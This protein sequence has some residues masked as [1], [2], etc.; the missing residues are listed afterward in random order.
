MTRQTVGKEWKNRVG[1]AFITSKYTYFLLSL[2]PVMVQ[3]V[4][5]NNLTAAVSTLNPPVC[6]DNERRETQRSSS[7]MF[8][9][10]FQ[11]LQHSR[12]K[13][14]KATRS[15]GLSEPHGAF[16]P[17]SSL[18]TGKKMMYEKLWFWALNYQ[19]T[20]LKAINHNTKPH[21]S[22]STY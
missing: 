17:S 4:S 12:Q 7:P 1:R 15:W 14:N 9:L 3:G 8:C 6:G 21:L 10:I 16:S 5:L 13:N 18:G 19:T 20:P 2:T 11:H 22:S